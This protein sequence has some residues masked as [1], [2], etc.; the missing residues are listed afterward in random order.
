MTRILDIDYRK[1]QTMDGCMP[2]GKIGESIQLACARAGLLRSVDDAHI[3]KWKPVVNA[4]EFQRQDVD[5]L[6]LSVLDDILVRRE[7]K[8][9]CYNTG[10]I[11]IET[12]T[13]ETPGW[14]DYSKADYLDYFQLALGVL[15]SMH[16]STLRQY[17]L[18]Q[19]PDYWT[20]RWVKVYPTL[21]PVTGNPKYNASGLTVRVWELDEFEGD[22]V[23]PQDFSRFLEPDMQATIQQRIAENAK[24]KKAGHVTTL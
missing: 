4:R 19:G 7:A 13:P 23:H 2:V 21:D 8:G 11:F 9:C 15:I 1:A 3:F 12:S 17:L 20:E 5:L 16:L 6:G 10:N 24:R 18:D 14:L 22:W